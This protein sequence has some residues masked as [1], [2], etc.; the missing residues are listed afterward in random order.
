MVSYKV[1]EGI[2]RAAWLALVCIVISC[3][4]QQI[5]TDLDSLLVDENH[6]GS[7]KSAPSSIDTLTHPVE[8]AKSTAV[9]TAPKLRD[10]PKPIATDTVVPQQEITSPN[11]IE[12][13]PP[14]QEP[15]KNQELTHSSYVEELAEKPVAHDLA[16]FSSD[17]MHSFGVSLEYFS[18]A[19][20]S[21]LGD[22]FPGYPVGSPPH[23]IEG[24]PKSTEYGLLFGLGYEGSFRKH[25]SRLLFRPRL[26]GELGIHQTY[27]GSSQALAIT[28]SNGDTTGF[29]FE[30]AKFSKTNYFAQAELDI[31]YCRTH[32]LTPYYLY[33]GLKGNVWYRDMN[34]DTLSYSNQITN[35]ELYYWFSLPIGLALSIPL[36]PTLAVEVDASVD[37]MFFG[38]MKALLSAWDATSTYETASPAVT[39][40]DKVGFRLELP[41]L[42]KTENKNVFRFVPYFR[43]HAFD[44]SETETSKSY[45]NGV[46]TEGSDHDFYEPASHS[47]L[48]GVKLQ[49]IFLSPFTRTY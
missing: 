10:I 20:V 47:W 9:D 7:V 41:I 17:R 25:G 14:P 32:A 43:F 5:D 33:S 28:N 44:Q 3:L 46:F 30:P 6:A 11:I 21:G 16:P 49:V 45:V 12:T 23:F 48:L 24:T 22:M 29:R 2:I 26:E 36:S 39:V 31:G 4:G 40:G 37:F 8:S 15:K 27:D 38:Q 13:A 42:Y 1:I 35:G 19:E 18:Y 34:D